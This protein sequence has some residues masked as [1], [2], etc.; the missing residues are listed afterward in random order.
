MRVVASCGVLAAGLYAPA[1]FPVLND[2]KLKIPHPAFLSYDQDADEIIISSFGADFGII[3]VQSKVFAM[4]ASNVTKD[5]SAV[6]VRTVVDDKKLLWP[7]LISKHQGT[8]MVPDGF[9][10]PGKTNG[11]MYAFVNGSLEPLA[12]ARKDTFYHR[13]DWVD[14]TGD[15]V[16]DLL[17]ARVQKVPASSPFKMNFTGQLLW[18]EA[19][20]DGS[21]T[22]GPWKEHIIAEGPDILFERFPHTL[23]VDGVHGVYAVFCSEFFAQRLTIHFV[24][25][26]GTLLTSRVIDADVPGRPFMVRIEDLMGDG[27][28]QLLVTNHDHKEE[29][30]R[31]VAYEIPEDIKDG[32]YTKHVLASGFKTKFSITP[33]A[34]SPG[35]AYG[36]YPRT[37]GEGP[38]HI[39]L[40][41]DGSH[42]VYLLSPV[43][44]QRLAYDI[45]TVTDIGGTVGALLI[46]DLDGDGIMDVLVANNDDNEIISF[47]FAEGEQ[48]PIQF[49]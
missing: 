47:T 23:T 34:A 16:E 18:L 44:D 31:V 25:P 1:Y 13:A 20:S 32:T 9:L 14:F 4:P 49:V 17:T 7:N 40:E 35:F 2:K 38:K 41:G 46:R 33:G 37:N 12:P 36:F 19:P 43:Q 39:L 42:Q 28:L 10:P 27:K 29:V 24:S 11:N 3:E 5:L 15:G 48:A 8:L 45:K 21:Y 30:A 22:N 26:T 6:Q